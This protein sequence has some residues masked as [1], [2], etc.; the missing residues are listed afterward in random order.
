[1]SQYACNYATGLQ[2]G[3]GGDKTIAT[4]KPFAGYDVETNRQKYNTE[5]TTQ[6]LAGYYLP[7]FRSCF[8]DAKAAS[9]MCSHN[10]LNGVPACS[11]SYLLEDILCD[12]WAW[13]SSSHWSQA[14]VKQL[15]IY[16]PPVKP[17][18]GSSRPPFS[19]SITVPTSTVEQSILS[20][21]V[22]P[23]ATSLSRR[24]EL[25]RR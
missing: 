7:P 2:D 1:V 5:I 24:P 9:V 19:P 14:I 15:K 21:W 13:N 11:N 17:Q 20:T 16:M 3:I 18:M 12:H 4:C 25:T 10:A 8:R 22:R 23:S 6:D